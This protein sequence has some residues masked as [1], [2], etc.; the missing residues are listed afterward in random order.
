MLRLKS[1]GQA[2]KHR[3]RPVTVC[4]GQDVACSR[5]VT[6]LGAKQRGIMR[7][8]E[9]YAHELLRDESAISTFPSG[10]YI[11]GPQIIQNFQLL[12]VNVKQAT[13]VSVYQIYFLS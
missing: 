2:N 11:M 7:R 3:P 6:P 10:I 13:K 9:S 8:R 1:G 5:P 4:L 12:H